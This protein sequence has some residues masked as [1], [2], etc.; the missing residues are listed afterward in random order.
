MVSLMQCRDVND[1]D[2]LNSVKQRWKFNFLDEYIDYTLNT[3]EFIQ[4]ICICIIRTS[5]P[6]LIFLKKIT[7][8]FMI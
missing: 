1:D 6:P 3:V 4:N 2:K 8:Y 5:K 7:E